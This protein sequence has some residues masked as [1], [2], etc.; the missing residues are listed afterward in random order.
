M[1]TADALGVVSVR[2]GS[3]SNGRFERPTLVSTNWRKRLDR[4]GFVL[5]CVFIIFWLLMLQSL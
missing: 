2:L 3:T 5:L 1:A 4:I